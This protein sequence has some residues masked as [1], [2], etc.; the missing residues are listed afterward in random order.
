M[1]VHAVYCPE[2]GLIV[3]S[4]FHCYQVDAAIVRIMKTRRSLP[5]N[6]LVSECLQQLRFDIKVHSAL[7]IYIY[8]VCSLQ[9][10]PIIHICIL[11]IYCICC[12]FS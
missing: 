12:T 7:Y 8:I 4:L 6:L 5:H 3:L 2:S 1:A 9:Y 11:Y 10:L